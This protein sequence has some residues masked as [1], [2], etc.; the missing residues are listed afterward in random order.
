[1]KTSNGFIY[2]TVYFSNKVRYQELLHDLDIETPLVL[3]VLLLQGINHG[4]NIRLIKGMNVTGM[5]IFSYW[6]LGRKQWRRNLCLKVFYGPKK[7]SVL[8][9]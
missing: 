8:R 9:Q 3:G 2:N 1:M 7:E 5:Y 4:V 6:Q